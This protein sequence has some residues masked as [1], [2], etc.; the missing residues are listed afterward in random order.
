MNEVEEYHKK[1]RMFCIKDDE[2][3]IA[4]ANLTY[5]HKEWFEKE[6]WGS[7]MEV[8]RGIV[9]E[10]GDIYFYT[11]QNFEINEK[12]EEEFF[13]HLPELVEKLNL[14]Q[15]AK[16]YGGLIKQTPGRQWPPKKEFGTVAEFGF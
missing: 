1:R 2:L 16:I 4:D 11:G 12:A 7:S 5:S 14:K 13:K 3:F 10:E 6:G 8:I 15:T 9:D